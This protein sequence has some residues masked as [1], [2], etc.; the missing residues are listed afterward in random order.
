M[1]G[2]TDALDEGLAR[3]QMEACIPDEWISGESD[4]GS[5]RRRLRDGRACSK[6]DGPALVSLDCGID[7]SRRR[8]HY[9]PIALSPEPGSSRI[10]VFHPFAAG[11]PLPAAR[12]KSRLRAARNSRNE[13]FHDRLRLE[14]LPFDA[15]KFDVRG[16]AA[17]DVCSACFYFVSGLVATV[18][19][20]M[21]QVYGSYIVIG[22][23]WWVV[24]RLSP[25]PAA[26]VFS[27][28]GNVSPLLTHRLPWPAMTIAVL[29]SGLLFAVSLKIVQTREY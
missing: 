22:I 25:P 10:D 24:N 23:A 20:E 11:Q 5:I 3:D 2:V 7:H 27:F 9:H 18:L 26:D 14:S 1:Q 16:S 13:R 12:G 8:G 28:L 6:P 15:C 17:G 29:A 21:W 4:H 19:D